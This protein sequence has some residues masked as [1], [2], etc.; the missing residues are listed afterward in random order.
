MEIIKEI[1]FDAKKYLSTILISI[2]LTVVA[3]V[4]ANYLVNTPIEYEIDSLKIEKNYIINNKSHKIHVPNCD[5]AQRMSTKNKKYV[6]DSLENLISNNYYICDRCHSGLKRKNELLSN[7]IAQFDSLL[8]GDGV[9]ELPSKDAYLKSI[10]QMGKWYVEHVST[11]CT[12]AD[13][14][15][16][17][18]AKKYYLNNIKNI[19]KIGNLFMYPCEYLENSNGGYNQAGDDCVRFWFSCLNAMD[20]NFVNSI[21]KY[22][23]IKWSRITS[24]KLAL[25]EDR[26]QYA[27]TNLGFEIYDQFPRSVDI[28]NDGCIDFSVLPID[29]NFIL[30]K[31]DVISRNGHIHI[32]LTDNE[33]FGWGK[34]NNA[35]PQFTNTYI[36]YSDNT[37]ICTK[38]KFTR[39]YR[40]NGNGE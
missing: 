25:D 9:I 14:I 3:I 28:N 20:I 2:V 13:D 31:G 37:I 7:I 34:V 33:N 17:D 32:Y 26:L 38:E 30:Q 39:V 24:R 10:D 22:S 15:A 16:T 18:D 27:L 6:T 1:L 4:G 5:S 12:V 19:N 21:S 11:Y 29:E 36:D 35:Y 8:F 40:Y 23:K